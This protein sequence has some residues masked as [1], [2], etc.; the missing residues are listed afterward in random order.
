MT[1]SSMPAPSVDSSDLAFEQ[2]IDIYNDDDYYY[3]PFNYSYDYNASY[4][5]SHL[6]LEEFVPMVTVYTL[7]G[8]LGIVGNLLVIFSIIKVK[9]MRSITNLFLLSLAT[10][11]LLLVCVCV[12]SRVSCTK[13]L[14]L[15]IFTIQP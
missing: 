9:R 8:L 13:Y 3:L 4:S 6:P 11:D 10:A 2:Y 15:Y 5:I 12:P 1:N 14:L 7:I